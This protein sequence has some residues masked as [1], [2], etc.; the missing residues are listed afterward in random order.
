MSLPLLD[1]VAV[2]RLEVLAFA[3]AFVVILFWP[4]LS[5]DPFRRAFDAASRSP[6]I[7][8]LV[9]GLVAIAAAVATTL[10]NGRPEP[11]YHDEFSYLLGAK[12]FAQGR[13]AGPAPPFAEHFQTFHVLLEPSHA[14]KYPPGQGLALALGIVLGGH[15][16]WGVWLMTGLACSGI[17]WMLQ[18]WLPPRWAFLGGLLSAMVFGSFSDWSQSYWG[19]L[20]AALGGALF[21]GGVRRVTTAPAI[22]AGLATGVGTVVLMIT[23]PFEGALSVALTGVALAVVRPPGFW[24]QGRR[25][26]V[27]GS[28]AAATLAGGVLLTGYYNWRV[29]GSPLEMPYTVYER[30][31]RFVP[32]LLFLPDAVTAGYADPTL[33]RFREWAVSEYEKKR[34][35][36]GF[37]SAKL[38]EVV[39]AWFTFG[40]VLFLPFAIAFFTLRDR[41][42]RT[43][44]VPCVGLFLVVLFETWTSSRKLAPATGLVMLF[45]TS[46]LQQLRVMG[47]RMGGR[48]AG[49]AACGAV[50]VALTASS[51]AAFSGRLTLPPFG[52]ALRRERPQLV[53]LLERQPRRQLVIVRY[54]ATHN[55]HTEW[56][57]NDPD[58]EAAHVVWARDL[59]DERNCQLARH[60]SD[61]QIWLLQPD[62]LPIEL[63]PY[64]EC[65]EPAY[66]RI[67][68]QAARSR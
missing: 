33:E 68:H 35:L 24:T 9:P 15:P 51:L 28:V 2:L 12:T 56:V 16:I 26:L 39:V 31:Y 14:S 50:L 3:F 58:I 65:F 42:L 36:A 13:L 32:V 60:F 61:R 59:G 10:V 37:A 62:R 64:T 8:W 54:S 5:V 7:G 45:A 40:R 19:G 66:A 53:A 22:A 27:A 43:A 41:W 57:Y 44:A 11:A 21:L 49:M 63:R 1:V 6:V 46:G 18:A 47:D 48:K 38:F 4:R 34:T 30:Q 25:L 20:P 67:A 23:R 29:A 55:V 17:A 52:G